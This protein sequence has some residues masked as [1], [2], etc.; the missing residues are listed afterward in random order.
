VRGRPSLAAESF[1]ALGALAGGAVLFALNRQVRSDSIFSFRDLLE[2]LGPAAAF[3]FT[4]LVLRAR[5]PGNL[6]GRLSFTIGLLG[7][8]SWMLTEYSGYGLVTHPGSLPGALA[9]E[10][11]LQGSWAPELALL[12]V[13]ICVFPD[14]RPLPG[15][16]RIVPWAGGVA[17]GALW[18]L[19]MTAPP[20]A[21]FQHVHDPLHVSGH[22][23]LLL[24]V[25]TA[26]PLAI[27]AVS[28]AVATVVVRFRRARDDEREQLKWLILAA[29][30][31][32]VGL[33]AHSIADSVAPRA[34]NTIELLFSVGVIAFPVAIG[35][36]VL[37]YRL[38]EIDRIV[39]RTLSYG[40][41]SA[42]LAGAY[43]AIV[44]A[45]QA[46]ELAVACSTLVVA[47]L[48]RP[49]RRRVQSAVDRR[50][51]RSRVNAD[52]TLAQFAARLRH[53]ADLDAL[54]GELRTVVAQTLAPAHV[55]LWLRSDADLARDGGD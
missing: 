37:K 36:A 54:L 24:L 46:N 20:P 14:G 39:S 12:V 40:L 34:D 23:P 2:A 18:L 33:V 26:I 32:P 43:V 6:V 13:L 9:I 7:V 17:F 27:V 49:L 44:L 28:G 15:R 30:V 41:L 55:S 8:V 22:S 51:Y 31:L 42:L 11:I 3:F 53:E 35:I 50:F 48:F 16:W 52:E 10:V 5:R 25:V 47:A 4:G 45:L 21:P 1:A 19:G 38:Y 29:S